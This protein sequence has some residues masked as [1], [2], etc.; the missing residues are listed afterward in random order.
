MKKIS[1]IALFTSLTFLGF[2]QS[3]NV[4]GTVSD[5]N[6]P[7][8]NA[9]VFIMTISDVIEPVDTLGSTVSDENGNFNLTFEAEGDTLFLVAS[10]SACPD[11]L[12]GF[13]VIEN[14]AFVLID[15]D[16][17]IP[18]FEGVYIGG[19]PT[20]ATG[21]QWTFFSSVYGDPVSYD[22]TIDGNN[23]NTPE[24]TYLFSEFGTYA[25]SLTVELASGTI[26][27]EEI[28]VAVVDEP[29]CTALF[30]PAIDNLNPADLV[31][32]NASIG[33]DLSYFWDFGDGTTS[34]EAFP[35]HQYGDTLEYEICLTVSGQDCEDTFCL[36]VS[37][38]NVFDWSGMILTG[39]KLPTEAKSADGY[40]ISI[41]APPTGTLL[42]TANDFD[43]DLKVY[44]NP[45]EGSTFLNFFSEKNEAAQIRVVNLTGKMVFQENVNVS[46]G[47]NQI[48][49]DFGQLTEG[50]YIM[51]IESNSDQRGVTK[52]I[53]R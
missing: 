48:N 5:E 41:I 53:I 26:L 17:G 16:S 33:D 50:L 7:I 11:L 1:L 6:G 24:V 49:L 19:V 30:F 52:V 20:N 18:I 10:S 21:D 38:S 51:V 15:C 23:F 25:V 3:I 36:T 34:T 40:E 12:N 28:D 35:T 29:I 4:T 44:P 46:R 39:E 13:A 27:T 9:D 31:F 42:S 14:E 47:K 43:L 45:T 32:V 37:Q 8:A 2:S 22:W